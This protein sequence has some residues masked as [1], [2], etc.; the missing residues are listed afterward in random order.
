MSKVFTIML[1]R[2]GETTGLMLY[3]ARAND[4]NSAVLLMRMQGIVP[5]NDILSYTERP[6][7][8]FLTGILYPRS[9][10]AKNA[11]IVKSSAKRSFFA[12]VVCWFKRQHLFTR[13]GEFG[14]YCKRCKGVFPNE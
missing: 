5:A 8:Q 2:H 7:R 14:Q 3:Q 11:D 6:T 1:R 10:E 12:P 4:F 13:Y 9:V